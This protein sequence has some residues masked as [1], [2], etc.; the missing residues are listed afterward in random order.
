M[1]RVFDWLGMYHLGLLEQET[2]SYQCQVWMILELSPQLPTRAKC[3]NTKSIMYR[4]AIESLPIN[5]S[6]LTGIR[7]WYFALI[8]ADSAQRTSVKQDG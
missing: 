6:L 1:P 3:M 7:S 8:L 2:F 4:S 5:M